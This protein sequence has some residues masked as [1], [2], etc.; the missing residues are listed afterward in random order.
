MRHLNLNP[1]IR[2]EGEMYHRREHLSVGR[3]L[4]IA[5]CVAALAVLMAGCSGGGSA[6][7]ASAAK[8][9]SQAELQQR[10]VSA[11]ARTPVYNPKAHP[12]GVGSK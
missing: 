10:G 6:P 1:A 9:P 8:A 3:K 7:A 2:I 5:A 11:H 4:V 12:T